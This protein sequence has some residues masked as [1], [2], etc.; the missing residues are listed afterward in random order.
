M[1]DLRVMK[2][3]KAI[4]DAVDKAA[5]AIMCILEKGIDKAMN[6]YNIKAK[7]A[8]KEESDQQGND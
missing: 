5:D 1:D 7:P 6:E 2:T 4:E 8:G 3:K